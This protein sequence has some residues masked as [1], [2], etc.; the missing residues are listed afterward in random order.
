MQS[1]NVSVSVSVSVS[2]GVNR[3]G[4]NGSSIDIPVIRGRRVPEDCSIHSTSFGGCESPILGNHVV[5][6]HV[7][8]RLE[9]C[10]SGR[11]S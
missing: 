4:R 8:M 7:Y 10:Q 3:N 9:T 11:R 5:R 1:G 6:H 2:V